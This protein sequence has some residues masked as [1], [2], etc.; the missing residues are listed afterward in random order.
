MSNKK[1]L[2]K[3]A[4]L[5]GALGIFSSSDAN[6]WDLTKQTPQQ[7][8]ATTEQLKPIQSSKPNAGTKVEK[9]PEARRTER[10][11]LIARLVDDPRTAHHEGTLK[12]TF[13]TDTDSYKV[14]VALDSNGQLCVDKNI[15]T[16]LDGKCFN[17]NE[18]EVLVDDISGGRY[19][20]NTLLFD[21][22]Q[23]GV[24]KSWIKDGV[25]SLQ[26]WVKNRRQ[27]GV[28][29]QLAS[30]TEGVKKKQAPNVPKRLVIK[31]E[32]KK[33]VTPLVELPTYHLRVNDDETGDNMLPSR[34]NTDS[35]SR[36]TTLYKGR[37]YPIA[38]DHP[39]ETIGV[40]TTDTAGFDISKLVVRDSQH[41][42]RVTLD[43]S[44]APEGIARLGIDV[45]RPT[46]DG[47]VSREK[48]EL[49]VN[50]V[51]ED[52]PTEY[53]FDLIASYDDGKELKIVD[54]KEI[55]KTSH[56]ARLEDLV[57]LG[58]EF[59]LEVDDEV[60]EEI[61]H[62]FRWR[63]WAGED[64]PWEIN[65]EE[66]LEVTPEYSTEG[67]LTGVR[68]KPNK[69]GNYE[70]KLLVDDGGVEETKLLSF[71]AEGQIKDVLSKP[72]IS[73]APARPLMEPGAVEPIAE[74]EAEVTEDSQ[75]K[76]GASAFGSSETTNFNLHAGGKSKFEGNSLGTRIIGTRRLGS[77]GLLIPVEL[78]LA[79][80]SFDVN[81]SATKGDASQKSAE[82]GTGIGYQGERNSA[83]LTAS[84]VYRDSTVK[85]KADSANFDSEQLVQGIRVIGDG[86]FPRAF[87]SRFGAEF[88]FDVE[89]TGV[90]ERNTISFTDF[91]G[92]NSEKK[93][94]GIRLMLRA[95][96]GLNADLGYGELGLGVEAYSLD[97]PVAQ[98]VESGAA[99][100][101]GISPF[102]YFETQKGK[103]VD[104]I[105][106][107]AYGQVGVAGPYRQSQVGL[108]IDLGDN[109]SLDAN[110]QNIDTDI[111]PNKPH[112]QPRA[113]RNDSRVNL[114][115]TVKSNFEDSVRRFLLRRTHNQY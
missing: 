52:L 82:V 42:E 37:K 73:R 57:G 87:N 12:L 93:D 53:P 24:P 36:T 85:L 103:I 63:Y 41:P 62:N 23:T 106:G 9:L 64:G 91:N 16:P 92:S 14:W 43:L 58:K 19:G 13:D 35:F 86:R 99:S 29:D 25:Y 81:G 39:G 17:P 104:N 45:I 26:L 65:L 21:I 22:D 107:A 68:V 48:E 70:L 114:G 75:I 60:G 6:A 89:A 33:P 67:R 38:V 50:V 88:G 78:E 100:V 71:S 111:V 72:D 44:E 101:R 34:L 20:V 49:F 2:L 56:S 31:E 80:T 105:S 7:P 10:I 54:L 61:E 69:K 32:P 98:G 96:A 76:Y 97:I 27:T 83:V 95:Q 66:D 11:N 113:V 28:V 1:V 77:T 47:K 8:A 115:L 40:I 102:A 30:F 109:V 84:F 51:P 3:G 4:L 74:P 94:L 79:L 18:L 108:R 5:G 46:K 110:Y 112:A 55:D 90:Q 15:G 59:S